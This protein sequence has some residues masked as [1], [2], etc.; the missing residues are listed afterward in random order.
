[1]NMLSTIQKL[2]LLAVAAAGFTSCVYDSYGYDSGYGYS[3]GGTTF[4]HTSS[5]RWLYDPSVRCYYDV[6]RSLYY[7]PY[8]YGYYPSGYCP[9]P[10][11]NAPHPYGWNGRG[12]CPI[13][14]GV[15]YHQIQN[16]QNR[17]AL[18]RARNY[19]WA[20]QVRV[21]QQA[22]VANWQQQRARAA[23]NYRNSSRPQQRAQEI[24]ATR[25]NSSGVRSRS[26]GFWNQPAPQQQQIQRQRGNQA[27]RQQQAQPSYRERFAGN[28]QANQ[29]RLAARQQQAQQAQAERQS[30]FQQ[31]RENQQQKAQEM[32]QR[33]NEQSNRRNGPW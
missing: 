17:V 32:M 12:N 33:R 29:E 6:Q 28:Q 5:S 11:Y 4:V 23:A 20:Q 19:Q 25:Q 13:P 16:Y 9:R 14:Q 1:M 21:N 15:R 30:R 22:T 8:L 7:D 18:L 10:V 31:A 3:G 24:Q 27:Q 2:A 26:Q